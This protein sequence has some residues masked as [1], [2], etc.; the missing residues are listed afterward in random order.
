MGTFGILPSNNEVG[1]DTGNC[2]LEQ[3]QV[4]CH[5][6]KY[7]ADKAS[8]NSNLT[9]SVSS[10]ALTLNKRVVFTD[11]NNLNITGHN[12]I[13]KCTVVNMGITF[14]NCTNVYLQLLSVENRGFFTE[15]LFNGY[16]A[17]LLLP[18]NN[19]FISYFQ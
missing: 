15:G 8:S 18:Y 1:T 6:L 2:L 16:S 4:S 14:V 17:F 12:T 9:V 19:C 5:S 7:V 13:I 10:K 11:V 3:Q